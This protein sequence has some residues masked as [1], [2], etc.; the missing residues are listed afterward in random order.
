M[1]H[2]AMQIT[3]VK[4]VHIYDTDQKSWIHNADQV[5]KTNVEGTMHIFVEMK[6]MLEMQFAIFLYFR[7]IHPSWWYLR[8]ALYNS[9]IYYVWRSKIRSN[10]NSKLKC[11][12][13]ELHPCTWRPK[14]IYLRH[15]IHRHNQLLPYFGINACIHYAIR[16][17]DSSITCS[18]AHTCVIL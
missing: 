2:F 8:K 11:C 15:K 6:R 3:T 7:W 14:S 17:L 13:Y 5:E 18:H 4:K 1:I 9:V 12:F 10:H 16:H